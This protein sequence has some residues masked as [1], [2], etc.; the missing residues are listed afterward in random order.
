MFGCRLWNF[1]T[2]LMRKMTALVVGQLPKMTNASQGKSSCELQY[3][4]SFSESIVMLSRSGCMDGWVNKALDLRHGRPRLNVF[5]LCH[6]GRGGHLQMTES[7]YNV[8]QAFSRIFS[9]TV[10]LSFESYD[11]IHNVSDLWSC[12]CSWEAEP[13]VVS[14]LT[15]WLED[16]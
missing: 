14:W 6:V 4:C 7:F 13:A 5:P 8:I 10:K 11:N 3:E 12:P 16:P 2:E 1:E 9:N 15:A